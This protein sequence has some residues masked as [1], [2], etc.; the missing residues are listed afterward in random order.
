MSSPHPSFTTLVRV[1]AAFKPS[2][3]LPVDFEHEAI[4]TSLIASYIP[5]D[6]TLTLFEQL[7]RSCAPNS[8][9]RAHMLVGTYGT[10]KSDLLLM[11]A[12]Y[13]ARASDDPLMH[14]FYDKL[15][16]LNQ[17]QWAFIQGQ[18]AQRPPYL[19]VVLQADATTP[20]SGFVL[21]GLERALRYVGQED[22]MRDTK[23]RA[24]RAKIAA[25]RRDQHRR[26]ADLEQHVQQREGRALSQLEQELDSP[27]ADLAFTVFAR[28]FREVLGIEF[29]IYE[30]HAAHETYAAVAQALA[31]RGTHSGIVV[32]ID[33]FTEFLR[34][35]QQAIDQRSAEID[36]E[37]KAV[38]NLAERSASSSAWK[39]GQLHFI[40]A[41][42]ESF[43]SASAESGTRQAGQALERIG[44]RFRQHSV[45]L[46]GNEELIRGAIQKQV[47]VATLLPNPQQDQLLDLAYAIWKEQHRDRA[48]V[49]DTIVQGAF[50]LH[51]LTTYALPNVN[52]AVAQSQRTMFLFLNDHQRGLQ[53]F[54]QTAA[55]ASAYPHWHTL[56]T[57]DWLF[58]Y[59]EESIK[60]KKTEIE[61]AYE[62]G[63]QNLR[64]A[65]VDTT[66]ALRV[67]KIVALCEVLNDAHLRPTRLFIQ[68]ALNL[69]PTVRATEE[70]D[71]ALHILEELD[72]LYPPSEHERGSQ[73]GSYS[74]PLA[75]RVSV[76]GLRQQLKR[77]AAEKRTSVRILTARYAPEPVKAESYNRE[78]GTHR[79]F[80]AHYHDLQSVS[81]TT[82]LEDELTRN[83]GVLVY[84]IASDDNE[85]AAAQSKARELTARHTHLIVAVP[86]APSTILRSLADY[87]ALEELYQSSELEPTAKDY[88]H[89]HGLIGKEY[90]QR[91][92]ADLAKLRDVRQWE[93]YV[94]GNP[95]M[96]GFSNHKQ[97]TDLIDRLMLQRFTATPKQSL[98]QHFKPDGI[99]PTIE[100]AVTEL[101]KGKVKIAAGAKGQVETVL[102]RSIVELGLLTEQGK[103]GGYVDYAITAPDAKTYDSLQ[104]WNRFLE[105]LKSKDKQAWARLVEELRSPPYGLYD[106]L[107][108]VY[109]AAFLIV[110]AESIE[111]V[112]TAAS[113]S[114]SRPNLGTLDAKLLKMM[115]EQPKTYTI[116]FQPLTAGE[117]EW[118]HAVATYDARRRFS[119]S[120]SQGTTLRAA[121]SEHLHTWLK[122]LS[123]PA[124]AEK[125]SADELRELAPAFAGAN[126]AVAGILLQSRANKQLLASALLTDI[127]NQLGAARD[128]SA[129]N[130][131]S[132][133]ELVSGFGEVAQLLEQLPKLLE[134]HTIAQIASVFGSPA[135]DPL[136]VWQAIFHWRSSRQSVNP[137]AL[138]TQ[139]RTFFRFTQSA[140]GT[141]QDAL[142]QE[143]ARQ[144]IGIGVEYKNW[145]EQ[146]RLAKLVQVITS[147]K[148]EVD[149]KWESTAPA[150]AV[151]HEG[152]AAA[153][154][155]R[156]ESNVPL[157]LVAERLTAWFQSPPLPACASALSVEQLQLLYPPLDAT[158][159]HDLAYLLQRKDWSSNQWE[160]LI[161]TELAAQFGI[162]QWYKEEVQQGLQRVRVAL[163]H[164][165]NLKLYL[166]EYLL[167]ALSAYLAP[168]SPAPTAHDL[169]ALLGAWLAQH[170]IPDQH[171]LSAET[172]LV[173]Q[174]LKGSVAQPEP[175]LLIDLPRALPNIGQPYDQWTT[176]AQIT[177]YLTSV[178]TAINELEQ[179][180][181]TPAPVARWLIGI[182][183]QG[184][185]QSLPQRPYEQTRLVQAVRAPFTAWL[186][187]LHLPSFSPTLTDTDLRAL[188]PDAPP[189]VYAASRLCIKAAFNPSTLDQ[190]FFLQHLPA[191]LGNTTPPAMWD[192][193]HVERLLDQ[194][195]EICTSLARIPYQ[196][197]QQ[198]CSELGTVL[199]QSDVRALEQL[200]ATLQTWRKQHVILNEQELSANAKAVLTVLQPTGNEP[201]TLLLEQL[202][203][204]LR[205]VRAPY[206]QWA[207]WQTR[208]SYRSALQDAVREIETKGRV[209][210]AS[211][212]VQQL[213][214]RLRH[215]LHQLSQDEQRW[216][217]KQFSEEFRQ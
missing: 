109:L 18:R 165:Q 88:L 208:T 60:T 213:W 93:W 174:Y 143:F 53:H 127:P 90:K 163:Q 116:R 33:E 5:T 50:P 194:F 47:D 144:I 187:A 13:F 106:A 68:H 76:P 107:L 155:G 21:H 113:S 40:V 71:T 217:I 52:R 37:T 63:R 84:I 141:V 120:P 100:K 210:V 22:L 145:P 166:C 198:L 175:A 25:W 79:E 162:H 216:L 62:R 69:P 156:E 105:H 150:E 72:T 11:I 192:D 51:P 110:H 24:A 173:L 91:L 87:Q 209:T 4:N 186:A 19:V 157:A 135:Q 158:Q 202:P 65:T 147:A 57:L 129:W 95:H 30:Y 112:P 200:L 81:D 139:T 197:K 94:Q 204:Q 111:I 114:G 7:A 214:E 176:Y 212:R 146:D 123:L 177:D 181:P 151:W 130:D 148:R 29:P 133:Q 159:V 23:Y 66:L 126:L 35:F 183:E 20:F 121:V 83:D 44:G 32:V 131:A 172:A 138:T 15:R 115:V 28:S 96:G 26:L 1:D 17:D 16:R 128:R 196:L 58:D 8:Q 41:S 80:V 211:E 12:N 136:E 78:R 188:F 179:Y 190:N 70:L 101:L 149:Q 195:A 124:F 27:Q 153:T 43:A 73:H 199:D 117:R 89:D 201:S 61:E 122:R 205:E 215:D 184:L 137:D 97:R 140:S 185:G 74:L 154:L 36:A 170:P 134:Q 125:L 10:G 98:A 75:G 6:A 193:P 42:L 164:A 168:S 161:D 3:Q 108:M 132:V 85:R 77:R 39:Y 38:D 9:E 67:L 31:E 160:P 189:T 56:L 119:Y 55:L 92:E 207:S 118:L 102:N 34:R 54:L 169:T 49:R 48:W 103:S 45:D 142:L 86:L 104:V 99:S 59:F 180:T 171:D 206:G 178:R 152:L 2:V 82:R 167:S 64:G 46:A 191:A 14:P 203:K 182:I